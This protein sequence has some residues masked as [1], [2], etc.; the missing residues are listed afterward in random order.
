MTI[1]VSVTVEGTKPDL[2]TAEIQPI[3]HPK[4]SSP[5]N[6]CP[7]D[8]WLPV[9]RCRLCFKNIFLKERKH[10]WVRG[11]EGGWEQRIRN[12]LCTESSKPDVGLEFTKRENMT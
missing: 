8:F 2:D 5:W 3:P 4:L 7:Q 10:E 12:R 1:L 11:R 9:T 6:M